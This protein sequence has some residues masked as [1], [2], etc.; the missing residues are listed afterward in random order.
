[1]ALPSFDVYSARMLS[2]GYDEVVERRWDP[3]AP[4]GTHTCLLYTSDAADE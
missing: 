3:N 4:T 2:A 1:M